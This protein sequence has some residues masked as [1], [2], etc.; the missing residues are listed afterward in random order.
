LILRKCQSLFARSDGAARKTLPGK[1]FRSRASESGD[2]VYYV[3]AGRRHWIRDDEWLSC[4]GFDE[5]TDVMEVDPDVMYANAN[6][7]AAPL[8]N[9]S[10][11]KRFGL[12]SFDLR[13]IAA[14]RLYGTGIEFGAGAS[15]FAVPLDCQVR[16]ADAFSY[17]SLKAVMYPGQQVQDLVRP[18]YL[19]D[20]KTLSGIADA[21][22]DFIVASHVIEH[23]NNPIKALASCYRALKPGG[24]LLLVI[25]DMHKT[26]DHKR[27]P[28]SLLHVIED[29][30]MPSRA[31]D[32]G[33]FEE[34]YS[35]AFDMPAGANLQ[36]YA[37]QKHNE[38][39]DI[40]YHSWT[41]PS[42]GKLVNWCCQQQGWQIAFEHPT[43]AGSDN[44]EFYFVLSK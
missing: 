29:F 6:S 34:F 43:L 42:F 31:R 40:H 18:D 35:K 13:E 7:G 12:T 8:R 30:A 4:N 32:L 33:H 16:F 41:Y 25:P 23:T 44:I 3:E 36:E 21:S 27:E 38:G 11:L 20:I 1:L 10:D 37:S 26:F 15:P 24:S 39:G 17:E 2:K 9:Q 28:T 14:S 5:S 22:L 19:T